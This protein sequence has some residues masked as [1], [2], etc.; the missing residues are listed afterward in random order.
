[1]EITKAPVFRIQVFQI[2]ENGKQESKI[3]NIYGVVGEK[4]PTLAELK[5]A[6]KDTLSR[7][8]SLVIKS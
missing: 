8:G 5:E 7:K 1:M 2:K 6:I 4:Y 3:I